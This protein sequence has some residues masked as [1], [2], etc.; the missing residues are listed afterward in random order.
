MSR[1]SRDVPRNGGRTNISPENQDRFRRGLV[2]A[3]IETG[4]DAFGADVWSQKA[5]RLAKRDRAKR[6]R[7]RQWD[8]I[9]E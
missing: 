4:S 1:S 7:K 2:P 8:D 9:D 3:P 5:K 6:E